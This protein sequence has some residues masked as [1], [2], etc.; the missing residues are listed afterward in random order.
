MSVSDDTHRQIMALH[1]EIRQAQRVVCMFADND[2]D[3]KPFDLG[4]KITMA[5]ANWIATK[6]VEI[7]RLL[8][9]EAGSDP[10]DVII[11][12]PDPIVAAQLQRDSDIQDVL[13]RQQIARDEVK[14]DAKEERLMRKYA[15]KEEDCD[16]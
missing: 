13:R 4:G 2:E 6:K 3:G 11:H 8:G 5:W 7:R 10:F 15:E 14:R 16:A 12:N 9:E 1:E